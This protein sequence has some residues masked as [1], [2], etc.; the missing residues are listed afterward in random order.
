MRHPRAGPDLSWEAPPCPAVVVDFAPVSQLV[1]KSD[2]LSPTQAL[3][4]SLEK[5][6]P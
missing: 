2:S 4:T 1:S 5:A 3:G 6:H